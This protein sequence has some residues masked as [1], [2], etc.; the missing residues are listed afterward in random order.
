MLKTLHDT[1]P[2]IAQA[3]FDQMKV[4]SETLKE[5]ALLKSAGAS[6][7]QISGG[8]AWDKIEKLADGYIEKAENGTGRATAIAK[9]MEMNPD[10]Y[11]AYLQENPKQIGN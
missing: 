8:S 4:A 1:A 3:Q 10:L 11:S 9:V 5:S 6:G 2:E 7:G